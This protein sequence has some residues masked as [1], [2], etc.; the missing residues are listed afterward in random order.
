MLDACSMN[1]T[2]SMG[3]IYLNL[4]QANGKPENMFPLELGRAQGYLKAYC[5][6]R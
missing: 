6:L 4:K 2:F 3:N 1:D 5:Q